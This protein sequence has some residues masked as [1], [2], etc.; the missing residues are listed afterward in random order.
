MKRPIAILSTLAAAL[1]FVSA[2]ASPEPVTTGWVPEG[3]RDV[4]DPLAAIGSRLADAGP[5]VEAREGE[6]P[7]ADEAAENLEDLAREVTVLASDPRF[8]RW[9]VTQ[10]QLRSRVLFLVSDK[11]EV[12]RSALRTCRAL[13]DRLS[14]QDGDT[15]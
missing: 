6:G 5:L 13:F 12:R 9:P 14:N 8:S 4:D 1:L 3:V 15:P 11:V 2:C 10:A 7:L